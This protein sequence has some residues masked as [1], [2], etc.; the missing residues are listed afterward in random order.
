MLFIGG[1]HGSF[2]HT[3]AGLGASRER[4]EAR[5]HS[6]VLLRPLAVVILANVTKFNP[7]GS[8][9]RFSTFLG[10]G[11]IDSGEGIAVRFGK[12]YVTGTSS[13][14]NFPTTAG[15]FQGANAGG[16]DGFVAKFGFDR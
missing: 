1:R 8:A 10:G 15:A 5:P 6:W 9:L 4:H 13:S 7:D 2:F 12:I 11:G 14:T 3:A 16:S